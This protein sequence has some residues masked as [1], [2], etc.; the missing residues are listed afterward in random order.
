MICQVHLLIAFT[1]ICAW[2]LTGL[3][4]G[5]NVREYRA[6]VSILHHT[7]EYPIRA[8]MVD[9]TIPLLGVA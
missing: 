9:R 5:F 6:N 1:A 8:L 4:K 2:F 3:K 7:P